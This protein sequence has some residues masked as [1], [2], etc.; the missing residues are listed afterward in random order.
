MLCIIYSLKPHQLNHL[1]IRIQKQ[2]QIE[3]CSGNNLQPPFYN[4]FPVIEK[5]T[6]MY[7]VN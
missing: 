4:P 5:M 7:N 2:G 6:Q 3:I 1:H